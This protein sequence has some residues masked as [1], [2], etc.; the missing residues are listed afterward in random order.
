[1]AQTHCTG[2]EHG[3]GPRLGLGPMGKRCYAMYTL[4]GDYDRDR[5]PMIP[6]A[7]KVCKGNVFTGFCLSIVGILC[8]G[9]SLSKGSLSKGS[10]C[11]RGGLC[12][13][14]SLQSRVGSTHSCFL[15][16][17]SPSPSWSRAFCMSHKAVND[18]QF[19]PLRHTR[20]DHKNIT[21][22]IMTTRLILN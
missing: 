4:H 12:Q 18:Q 3:Q 8:P 1:M 13:D 9:R 19:S 14:D 21:C 5:E 11:P 17:P 2:P 15:L 6:P 16:Y 7:H 22:T 10:L 20:L